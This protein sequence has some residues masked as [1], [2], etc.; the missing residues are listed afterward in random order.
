[1]GG[2]RLLAVFVAVSLLTVGL[3]VVGWERARQC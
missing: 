2:H 3:P 1:M